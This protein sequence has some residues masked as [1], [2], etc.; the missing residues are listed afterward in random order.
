MA[1]EQTHEERPS[2]VPSSALVRLFIELA[3]DPERRARELPG[4]WAQAPAVEDYLEACVN[5]EEEV[6]E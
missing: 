5:E 2:R 6:T 4:L 1:Y 3:E